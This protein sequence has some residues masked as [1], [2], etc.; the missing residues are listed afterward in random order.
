MHI[1]K[2]VGMAAALFAT[3]V[4]PAAEG[5]VS[6]VMED[7]FQNRCE[8][9]AL[10]GHVVVLVYA[11]RYG[12]EAAVELGRTLHTHYHP[13]AATAEP[14]E[15]SKQPVIG[16]PGWPAEVPVPDVHVIP[17]ACVPEVPKMLRGMVRSQIRKGSPHLPV[18][19]DYEDAM[20]KG[21]GIVPDEPNVLLIDTAGVARGVSAGKPDETKYKQLVEAIDTLRSQALPPARTAAVPLPPTR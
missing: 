5:P 6:L 21:F 19:L 18:W 17:I 3:T 13:T 7:Q 15:R 2:A 9:E 4:A 8:T 1:F 16:I 14:A 11:G 20:R 10:R 12:A